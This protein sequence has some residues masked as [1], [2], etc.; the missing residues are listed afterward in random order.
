[1]KTL[2]ATDEGG[3]QARLH[4]LDSEG[5]VIRQERRVWRCPGEPQP[6]LEV[7]GVYTIFELA[8]AVSTRCTDVETIVE[9]VTE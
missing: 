2:G 7:G 9:S 1:V 3:W 8:N 5:E 4:L 6:R